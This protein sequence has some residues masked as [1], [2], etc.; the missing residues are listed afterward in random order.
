V[1]AACEACPEGFTT[2]REGSVTRVD[3]SLPICAVGTF[4]I[5]SSK[6]C[7]PCPKGQY[8]DSPQE[9]SCKACPTDTSTNSTGST[10]ESECVN[11]CLEKRCDR[12][13]NCLYNAVNDTAKCNCKTGYEG[14]GQEGHC[15][16]T[17]S[18]Y[19]KNEGLCLKDQLGQP[20]C[21]CQGSFAG[22]KCEEKSEFAYIAG[23]IAGAVIFCIL[24]VFLIWMICVR[25]NRTRSRTNEKILSAAAG[26]QNGSQVN[27][28][29]GAPAPYAESIAPSHH[30][31]YAHYYDDEEDGWEMPNFYNETYMKD[32]LHASQK[33]NSLARSSA[34]LYGN[35]DDL[36]DRLRRHAYQG[37]KS[38]KSGNET[39]SDSDPQ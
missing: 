12:N 32:G 16:D 7:E 11:A 8:Q 38:D 39:T 28:Y 34:S 14:N 22:P 10:S 4:L 25:A 30:S 17:C 35:K 26:E 36:Y 20:K 31:T 1:D 2:E 33:L 9:A 23:G 15:T 37:K 13:A 3:C 18:D 27:F 24:L 6:Q 19:C 5:A 29:Y 21:H